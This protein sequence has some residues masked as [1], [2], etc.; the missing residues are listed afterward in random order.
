MMDN[1]IELII[2]FF[3]I[4]SIL[5]MIIAGK[6]QQ[7]RRTNI[8]DEKEYQD[9]PSTSNTKRSSS[10]YDTS[11]SIED[12]FGLKLPEP[13]DQY[14]QNKNEEYISLESTTSWNPEKEFEEKIKQKEALEKRT[15]EKNIPVIDYDKTPSY[16]IAPV[17]RVEIQN[18]K[19]YEQERF[20]NNRLNEIKIK[21]KNPTTL[22]ELFIVSEILNKPISL[23]K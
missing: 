19:A 1:I 14:S 7:K 8:P 2:T 4:Y 12:L 3:V 13:E 17:K 5:N 11:I 18:I 16:E 21:L 15:I 23:R 20:I 10:K 9:F 22:K 6:K